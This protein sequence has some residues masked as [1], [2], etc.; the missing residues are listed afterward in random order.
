MN[1]R[2]VR[3]GLLAGCFFLATQIA[4]AQQTFDCELLRFEA[5][6]V[7][8]GLKQPSALVFLPD[9]R[10]LLVERQKGV[11]LFDADSGKLVP[12]QGDPEAL[13]GTDSGKQDPNRPATLTGEDAGYHDIVLHPD[14]AKNG[15]IY[16]SYSEGPRER[17]TTVVDRY[18]LRDNR[19][20]DRQRIFTADAYSED[21]FHYG[22]RM[23][24]LDGYLFLTVGERHHQ[25]RA[26]ELDTDAGKILR[27]RDDG[28]VPPDNPF[29]GT[30]DARPEIWSYGHRNP[31]GLAVRPETGELWEDEHGPLHGDEVN[32]IHRGGNYGWP[33]ISYGWQYSGGAI[34][35]GITRKDGMEQPVWVW[36]PSIAPS[37]MLFYT[38]SKFPQWHGDVFVGAMGGHHLSRLVIRDG[39]VVV[40]ERLMNGKSG[41][42]RLVAQSP[43]GFLYVGNDDGQLLQLR[44]VK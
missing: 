10:G 18:H 9:G 25:D 3:S 20:V 12:I 38:G 34:G 21:R 11:D 23:V 6:L 35:M 8:S 5:K 44:P 7:A 2:C 28:T 31:Q 16:L 30:K 19:F 22:G 1:I 27:L 39:H 14:Y 17:S 24:F 4:G 43:D 29:L 37:G 32:I 33:V 42:I 26:Q 40:E 41:R 15:W 13:V 36:T